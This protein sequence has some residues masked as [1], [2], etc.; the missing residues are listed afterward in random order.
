ME[1]TFRSTWR[2]F[3]LPL[4]LTVIVIGS[5]LGFAFS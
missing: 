1:N 2:S 4:I 5:A 3:A